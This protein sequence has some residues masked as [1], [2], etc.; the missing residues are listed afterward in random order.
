MAHQSLYRR[1][2]PRRFSEIKGQEHV[3]TALR[4]AVSDDTAGHAYLFSGPRG[5]GKTST[6]RILAKALNCTNLSGGEPCCECES[7]VAM[8]A[9]SSFDL[10]ELDAASN[11]GVDSV[12]ELVERTAVGSPGR[13]KVYILDEVHMLTKE[14][15]NALLKTLEEP[16]EHVRF[17]LATTDP[18]K[19]LPTI[20]S[21]TQH[22][23]FRLLSADELTEHVRWVVADA[24]LDVDDEAIAYAVRR[25]RGSVRDTLSA[26]DQ[27]VAAGGVTQRAE[28]VE[29]LFEALSARDS[30]K[31]LLAI[32]DAVSAGHDPRVLAEA[33]V[34]EVRDAFLAS[35]G[36]DTP[37][38][39]DTDA[40]RLKHWADQLGSAGLTAAM[41]RVGTALVDM[42]VA[43]DPRVPL[44]VALIGLTT[45]A[46]S[47]SAQGRAA[48]V[49]G[50]ALA[51]LTKRVEALEAG[52]GTT[53]TGSE[54][55]AAGS[56][57][58][59]AP[60]GRVV[61]EAPASS[62]EASSSTAA[63]TT[64]AS[65]AAA[66][67]AALAGTGGSADDPGASADRR[68]TDQPQTQD[69]DTARSDTAPNR[70]AGA[71]PRSGRRKPPPPPPRRRGGGRP[72]SPPP[73]GAAQGQDP[74]PA[75]G[76]SALTAPSTPGAPTVPSE[77]SAELSPATPA[78]PGEGASG[79]QT[80]SGAP[81]ASPGSGSPDRE[82]LVM[83][84]GDVV[85][86]QLKGMAKALFSAGR[87]VSVEGETAVFALDND[88]TRDRAEKYRAE[89]ESRLSAHFGSAVTLDLVTESD[90][91]ARASSA[92]TGGP[93]GT[94][95]RR[96]AE[97]ADTASLPPSAQ[98][99]EV[100]PGNSGQDSDS[101]GG[102]NGATPDEDED[103]TAP[104]EELED[105]DVAKTGLDRVAAAFPGA[106]IMDTEE[107]K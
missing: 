67:R 105:A 71:P 101:G 43:A 45:A 27:V 88:P 22:F 97:G 48:P 11:R 7:C 12:R 10:F 76:G 87:F 6:A 16:P 32:A 55:S 93:P 47:P 1:Y 86:P 89:V 50:D 107:S 73:T 29:A 28:P 18:Q 26:L 56:G 92:T 81:T 53:R 96:S 90:P 75:Q 85:V 30:G 40:Q 66:A 20:R 52:A 9:G 41:E 49:V 25:G 102:T 46:D 44:E 14:A 8:E 4:N 54:H 24:G 19:V 106:E 35:L 70:G 62:A 82:A 15:S 34:G 2:R 60:A 13:T 51:A 103:L 37:H 72:S 69:R 100:G 104:L 33:F 95:S 39:V 36:V 61:S 31:A 94:P 5:T 84:F 80:V 98:D 79:V 77:P 64:T 99:A 58:G 74:R 78:A 38:L 63:G 91:R 21:R 59:D 68:P 17:V 65:G 57:T 83:A 42:R 23:D 3:V